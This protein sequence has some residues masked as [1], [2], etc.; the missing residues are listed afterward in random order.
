MLYIMPKGM[1]PDIG[2][3]QTT[4]FLWTMLFLGGAA[5]VFGP[6]LGSM[7]FWFTLILTDG[8]VSLLVSTGW[9]PISGIQGGQIRFILVGV[10]LMLLVIY[11]PQGILGK[12]AETYFA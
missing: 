2:G 10:G 5:T 11:R 12:K 8:L 4:F 1:N 3:T 9:V 7:I 6:I